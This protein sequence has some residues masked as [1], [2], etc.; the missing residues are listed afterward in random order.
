MNGSWAVGSPSSSLAFI[1]NFTIL[2]FS[3]SSLS[4]S[5]LPP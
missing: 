3:F 1:S 2:P 4:P 5:V